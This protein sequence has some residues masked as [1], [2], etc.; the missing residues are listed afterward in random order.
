[1]RT[2]RIVSVRAPASIANFG[3]GFDSFGMCLEAPAD[4]LHAWLS[5]SPGVSVTG[6]PVPERPELNSAYVAAKTVLEHYGVDQDISIRLEK[7][8]RPGGGLGSSGASAAGGAFAAALLVGRVERGVMLAAGREGERAC[9]G[10]PHM[11]NLAASLLGGF[12]I[13]DPSTGWVES[14]PP[15][16]MFLAVILPS[17]EV[18]TRDARTLLPERYAREDV[19]SNIARAAMMVRGVCTGDLDLIARSIEDNLAVPYRKGLVPYYGDVVRSAR[20]SGALA[21]SIAGS[22]PAIFAVCPS[23]E[24]ADAVCAAA[25]DTYA[26]SGIDCTTLSTVPGGGVEPLDE[27][28]QSGP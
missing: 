3:P 22:G 8:I 11:D 20:R 28:T 25:R 18:S 16:E 1:M 7:R 17:R 9:S 6:H 23:G 26:S 13:S 21:V 19:V 24:A 15:P 14:V 2:E 5:P 10:A 12:T 4:R 27:R